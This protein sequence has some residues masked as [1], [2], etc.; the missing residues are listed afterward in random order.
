M[1]SKDIKKY[2]HIEHILKIPDTYIGST[3][4]TSE[5]LWLYDETNNKMKK[6]LINY[7]P[8]EYKIFDEILVNALDQNTRLTEKIKLGDNLLPVKNI[9]VSYDTTE[10]FI[11]ICNDGEGIPIEK[12]SEEDIYI[13]ELIFGHL[14]T[15]GNYDK[16]NKRTGGKN[17]YG[18]KLTNIF[19]KKF[20]IET[21]DS[22][23][24]KKYIQEFR[25]NMSIKDKPIITK[26]SGKPYTKITYYPDFLRFKYKKSELS[27]NIIRLITK[28]TFDCIAITNNTVNIYLN[29]KKLECKNFE[30]YIDL[31]FGDTKEG[32]ER[33]IQKIN[34]Y[35]N[36]CIAI[37]PEQRF[38]QVSF[39]NGI[40]TYQGGKHV[41]Y[42][43]NQVCKKL[44]EYILKK[45]KITVKTQHIK[46]NIF[47]FINS[48]ISDPT[49]NSQIKECL[50]TPLSK[51]GSKCELDSKFIDKLAKMG[52]MDLSINLSCFKENKNLKK[53]DGK[54]KSVLRGIPKL[55]DANWAGTSKSDQCTLIL[56]EGDS[57]KSFAISG[58][59]IIGRDKYGVFPL[60]GKVL[61]VKGDDKQLIKKIAEN[62]EI[63]NIKKIMGLESNKKY[64]SVK[65]L[66]YG[67]IL[68]LTD[69]DADGSHIKGLLFNL[70]HSLWDELFKFPG[71]TKSMLT[72][73]V[74]ITNNR[75][76]KVEAFYNLSDY[77][78]WKLNKN[79]NL[80]KI[81]YYKG[82]GTSTPK[83]AK[84]YFK[85]MK[86]ITYKF[87]EEKSDISMNLAFD[88][89]LADK[90]KEWLVDYNRD[91]VLD[92]HKMEITHEDF[93][94]KDL[95]HFSN[96]DNIRSIPNL[97]DGFKVSQRKVFYCTVKKNIKNEI[98]VAQ[99]AG[100]ISETGNYH[101]GEAS[102]QGT[103]VN[104]AQD[105][106]GSNNINILE[107][108]GQFGSRILGG[109]DSAEPR[110]IHTK[111]NPLIN[112]IFRKEDSKIL[113][114]KDNDGIIVE[115][116]YYIPIIPM[117]LVNGSEGIG[118]GWSTF[119]PSF[120]P[121]D[122]INN[123]RILINNNKKNTNNVLEELKPYYNNFTGKII[124]YNENSYL[125][126]GK[127][128]RIN[129]SQIEITELPIKTWIQNYKEFLESIT[130]DNS[131]KDTKKRYLRNYTSHCSDTEIKFILTFAQDTLET[132]L[133]TKDSEQNITYFEKIFK[134][135]SKISVSNMVLY[136]N[137]DKLYKYTNVCDILKDYYK[138]RIGC[139]NKRKENQ[140]NNLKDELKILNVKIRFIMEFINETIKIIKIKRNQV[141]KQLYDKEYHN[142]EEDNIKKD[143]RCKTN[144]FNYLIK[145][146][147]DVLTEEKLEELKK[148]RDDKDKYLQLLINT[149]IYDIYLKE[150]NELE[151]GYNTILKNENIE[152]GKKINLFKKK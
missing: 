87:E 77:E 138:I 11:S 56:T 50:T 107:P 102:L 17:G 104:M 79:L 99:L 7:I 98:R 110:Y 34:E 122:I 92:Y 55:D 124:K 126:Y 143:S 120:N 133:N 83:E 18:S 59:S 43:T 152:S 146:P 47:V 135:T 16:K 13:P 39:V 63:I 24:K 2:T 130:L 3:D 29:E 118:T 103:I 84:E 38:E 1:E 116:N 151:S 91:D 78:K 112:Y 93:I 131:I 36:I 80:Y 101:H 86:V 28:R 44:S 147:I 68:F 149:S 10:N 64:K 41:E 27:P 72:P 9:K 114:Y 139:Y 128:K 105:Y 25:D 21:V 111:I 32:P 71:F 12:H 134:L 57:A 6:E 150:L 30:K 97:L 81:K 136:Y 62:S 85:D 82:L 48:S 4:F 37:N 65:E 54:K 74:K 144:G 148:D 142:L 49:F 22:R 40:T 69:Q 140:I 26:Y 119:I 137:D 123:L 33:V 31:Y 108:N 106:I 132:L 46:E 88:K 115:P 58:L 14:L 67:S 70:F 61:N 100:Y 52:L 15:S 23:N 76:K 145:L 94:N 75:S 127:Y 129:K 109:K 42:I 20:I 141:I 90:R 125:S 53:T 19:S 45:K 73:I 121:S 35:W 95:K 8:G 117:L 113:D 51:F 66:R 5:E 89:K 96:S 60:K